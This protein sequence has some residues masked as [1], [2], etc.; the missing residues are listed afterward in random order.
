ARVQPAL[1]QLD[2]GL[3]VARRLAALRD[4]GRREDRGI[5]SLVGR[6]V[7][8]VAVAVTEHHAR[9]EQ[10]LERLHRV[11][12]PEVVEHLVPEAGGAKA[13]RCG[14]RSGG[15]G[16]WR[17]AVLSSSRCYTGSGSPQ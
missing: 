14:R 4:L 6:V 10:L 13:S 15:S 9:I 11:H 1:L 12:E 3:R 17:S 7:V 5:G 16:A 8:E 2:A